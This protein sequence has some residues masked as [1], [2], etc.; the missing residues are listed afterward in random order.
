M[1]ILQSFLLRFSKILSGAVPSGSSYVAGT[2]S[3]ATEVAIS[4]GE[5][6]KLSQGPEKDIV[7]EK[8]GSQSVDYS[9]TLRFL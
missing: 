7:R 3:K 2:I 5:A 8:E 6:L 4:C 1:R 9:V